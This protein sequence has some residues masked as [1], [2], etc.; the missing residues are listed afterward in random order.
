MIE[1]ICMKSDDDDNRVKILYKN[2]EIICIDN[3]K[4]WVNENNDAWVLHRW[5]WDIDDREI[6]CC[7]DLISTQYGCYVVVIDGVDEI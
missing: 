7:V 2:I 1:N 3:G 5:I 6:L 4:H